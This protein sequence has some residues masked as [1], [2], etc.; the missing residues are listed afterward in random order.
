M[1]FL[2]QNM[3]EDANADELG[4]KLRKIANHPSQGDEPYNLREDIGNSVKLTLENSP[5]FKGF[6][7]RC[8]KEHGWEDRD[9]PT[10]KDIYV[11]MIVTALQNCDPGKLDTLVEAYGRYFFNERSKFRSPEQHYQTLWKRI[12]PDK[13]R[14]SETGREGSEWT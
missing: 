4:R 8:R 1:T 10:I 5:K 11:G 3:A 14:P 7:E 9:C 12:I 2:K 6:I 13:N